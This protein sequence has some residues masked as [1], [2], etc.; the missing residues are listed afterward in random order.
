MDEQ[1]DFQKPET[2][3]CSVITYIWTADVFVYLTS[4]MDPLS[5]E[6]IA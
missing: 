2:V 5:R 6:I 1:F 3:W 4:I